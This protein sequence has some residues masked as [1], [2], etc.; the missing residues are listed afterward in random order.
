MPAAETLK[1]RY[2]EM[3]RGPRTAS[4]ICLVLAIVFLN[5]F[6][7]AFAEPVT[8]REDHTVLVGGRP[9]FPIGIY[10]T[11]E[12]F[13]DRSGNLLANLRDRGFNTVGCYSAGEQAV[14]DMQLAS[15][16]GLKVWVRGHNGLAV[17]SPKT[18][19]AIEQQVEQLR[20]QP[21]LLFWEFQD[22]PL[23]NKV[24]VDQSAKGQQIVKR[25]DPH[26]PILTV[27]W[28]GSA[29][30]LSE[31]REL[32]DIYGTDLYPIPREQGYGALPN[33]DITQMRDYLNLIRQVR[34][35]RPMML[36]LQAWNWYPLKYGKHGHPTVPES[37]F[38]A[39]QSVIHGATALFYYGQV[40][41]TRPNSAAGL[42]SDAADPGVREAEFR[43]CVE[44]N[45]GFWNEHRDFFRQL[46]DAARIF[47]LKDSADAER[48]K[49]AEGPAVIET[50]TKRGPTGVYVL[51]VNASEKKQQCSFRMP[52]QLRG[53]TM[54]VLFESR[55]V[56]V[57]S[58]TFADT[59]E[60]YG[61]HVYSTT[62]SLP[63]E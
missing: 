57:K 55:N 38:M 6:A 10:Y 62:A 58:G 47:V 33:K 1:A 20:A 34:G 54:H 32:G 63:S 51:A 56:P 44:L 52:A 31:W 23:L 4:L 61:V 22:E 50:R 39:Y 5:T 60:P 18:A 48:I 53:P 2:Y 46:R 19:A 12:E 16:N 25:L 17:D 15:Q 42:S 9:F 7:R 37:R 13:A 29:S 45:D 27:E 28:P 49:V 8:F 3:H 41:C 59:F 11:A 35:N 43:K 24:P 36:V 14:R 21:A 30:R 40:H 26:H